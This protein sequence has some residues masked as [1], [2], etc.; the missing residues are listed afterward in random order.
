MSGEGFK[1]P[2]ARLIRV[3]AMATMI[4]FIMVV[5]PVVGWLLGHWIGQRLS[6]PETGGV[7]GLLVGMATAAREV[8]VMIRHILD[9][10]KA[11]GR[12]DD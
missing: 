3:G 1:R 8:F 4:P 11:T 7:V 10:M 6:R 5:A 12:D 2:T 9:E